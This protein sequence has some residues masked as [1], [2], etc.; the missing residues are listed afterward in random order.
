MWIVRLA[1]RRPYTFTVM[2]ILIVLMGIA[3]T[4]QLAR[5]QEVSAYLGFGGAYAKSDGMKIDT[6]G[7]GNL[8]KTPALNG[9]FGQAGMSVFFGKQ[10]GVGAE[11]SRRL[12]QGDYAGLNYSASFSSLDGIYRPARL[13]S[14]RLE[15]EYRLV[16]LRVSESRRAPN[17]LRV[18]HC[19]GFRSDRRVYH[20]GPQSYPSIGNRPRSIDLFRFS[21]DRHF[22]LSLGSQPD[23]WQ[24]PIM[25]DIASRQVVNRQV[26]PVLRQKLAGETCIFFF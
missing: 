19:D 1:L 14:K 20:D 24:C 15:P 2:A 4:L 26:S 3:A 23:P 22:G 8:Y 13:T 21:I 5:A 12:V 7:D 17:L 6:F 11:I 25:T 9:P 10:W 16:S 18:G